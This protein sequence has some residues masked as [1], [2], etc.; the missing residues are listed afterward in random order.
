MRLQASIGVLMIVKNAEKHLEKTLLSVCE[1]VDEI[2]IVDA[3]STD[4]TLKIANRFPAKLYRHE[5]LGFGPQRQLA[6]RYMTTDW[7]FAIDADEEVSEALKH[8]ILKA[9]AQ[10]KERTLYQVNRLTQ[11]FGKFIRHSGWYPD[12]ITRL[13]PRLATEYND[14]LVH[15]SVGTP[16][17]YD[18]ELLVHCITIRLIQYLAILAK[19]SSIWLRGSTKEKGISGLLSLALL[20][21]GCF[22][23]LKCTF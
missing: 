7:V 15:E 22:D 16:P 12:K 1:W 6:Q 5:W 9:I 2:V 13:Y 8:S 20:H 18:I 11:A 21:M 23:L 14:A 10:N 19:P 3:G 4:S 17:G